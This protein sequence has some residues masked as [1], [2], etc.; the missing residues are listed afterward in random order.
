MG[1]GYHI[2]FY[3]KNSLCELDNTYYWK[4][5]VLHCRCTCRGGQMATMA[6]YLSTILV[7]P[8]VFPSM[9]HVQSCLDDFH[10]LNCLHPCRR[11]TSHLRN[12]PT[13]YPWELLGTCPFPFFRVLANIALIHVEYVMTAVGVVGVP[14][15]SHFCS[16]L[17]RT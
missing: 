15:R 16:L 5:Q 17:M 6:A 8:V 1:T 3:K 4:G 12:Q 2:L 9:Y 11:H 14:S 10:F 13:H 7:P